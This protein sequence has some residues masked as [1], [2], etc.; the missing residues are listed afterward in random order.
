MKTV[1][2]EE[3]IEKNEELKKANRCLESQLAA[4]KEQHEQE[5]NIASDVFVH[6]I[7]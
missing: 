5:V 4:S 3:Y 6:L 2:P 7:A 1:I